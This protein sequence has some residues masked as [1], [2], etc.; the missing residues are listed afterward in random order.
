MAIAQV[1]LVNGDS[2][3]ATVL[4][5]HV[6]ALENVCH[7]AAVRTRVHEAG[8]ANGAGNAARKLEA[9][10]PQ[11]ARHLGGL[12]QGHARLAPHLVVIDAHAHET[13]GHGNNHA[14]V[15][16]VCNQ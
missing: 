3:L 10:K 15:P 2:L 16:L 6:N 9:R 1:K 13:V 7:A 12:A 5:Q 8:T 11:L 14:A 4:M